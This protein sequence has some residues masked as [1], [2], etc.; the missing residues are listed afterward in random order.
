MGRKRTGTKEVLV[1]SLTYVPLGSDT[2][3]AAPEEACS[4]S[5]P[6]PWSSDPNLL[7]KLGRWPRCLQKTE[8]N[9]EED[10]PVSMETVQNVKD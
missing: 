9:K 5:K 6:G 1:Q 2:Q 7:N 4:L 8:E 10:L 3:K